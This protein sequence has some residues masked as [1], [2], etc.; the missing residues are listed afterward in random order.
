MKS[1]LVAILFL[2]TFLLSCSNSKL[3]DEYLISFVDEKTHK[4]GYK[5]P[6]GDV[7]IPAGK[8]DM[9][10]SDTF[11]T[12]AIVLK[13]NSKFVAID[14]DEKVMYEVFNYDNGP[15]YVSEGLFRIKKDEKIGFADPKSGKIVIEP[16][17]MCAFPFE[18]GVAKVSE[19]CKM[20]KE[21]DNTIWESED[22]LFINSKGELVSKGKM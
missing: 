19:N 8:Y 12:F 3:K 10:I 14:R 22:W 20:I 5:N 7:I 15:D 1:K 21:G 17:Y 13:D 9:C 16:K 6:I 4:M 11:Q 2:V 18:E